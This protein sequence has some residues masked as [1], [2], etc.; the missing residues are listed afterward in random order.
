MKDLDHYPPERITMGGC[1]YNK[2]HEVGMA[3]KR[4]LGRDVRWESL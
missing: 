4:K 2:G 3:L 1:Q